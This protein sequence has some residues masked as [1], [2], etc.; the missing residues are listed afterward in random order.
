MYQI[1]CET[2]SKARDALLL[3]LCLRRSGMAKVISHQYILDTSLFM[4][5]KFL[6]QNAKVKA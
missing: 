6:F 4:S 5:Q 2:L 3:L 1:I